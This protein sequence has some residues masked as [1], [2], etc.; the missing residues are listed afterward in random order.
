[1][2]KKAMIWGISLAFVVTGVRAQSLD[3]A[4]KAIDAEQ[5]AQ[6]KGML[7]TLVSN[8]PKDGVNYFY[9]GLVYIHNEHLDSALNV[10]NQ[11]LTADPKGNLNKVGQG[12]VD[13]YKE[14]GSAAATK[15][16][17]ATA[18]LKRKDYLE[19][20]HI[21]RAYIDA[22]QPD[23]QKAVEYLDQAKA[24]NSEDPL[25]P[26]ALG[27]AYFGLENPSQAYV[28]YRNA[29]V[30]DNTLTRAR[31]QM[32]V[33]TRGSHAWQEAIDGLKQ[34]ATEVP[35]YAPT[36]RELAETY[37]A[38]ANTATAIDDY[39]A[40]NKEAVEFYKQYMDKTDYTVESRIRYA[41]FLVYVKDYTELQAQAAELAQLEDVN[42]KV[43][44][45]LGYS[46]YENKQYQESKE[47]L[48]K[49][50]TRMEAERIIPLDYLH[51]GLTDV[52][53]ATA[54]DAV[55]EAVFNDGI[56]QLKKAV[57]LDSSIADDLHEVGMDLVTNK[58]KYALAAKVF[59][60]PA[61]T[62]TSRNYVFDNFYVGFA[63]YYGVATKQL[64]EEPAR[65]E[66]LQKADTALGLVIEKA[67]TTQDAYL[68]RANVNNL[69]DDPENPKGLAE[70]YFLKYIEMVK[71]KGDSE[72]QKN[73]NRLVDAY[74]TI[75]VVSVKR[76][77]YQK[78]RDLIGEI[79]KLDPENAWAKQTLQYLEQESAAS[80]GGTTGQ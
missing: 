64:A 15:F 66:W 43:L 74:S 60:I 62:P 7:E 33:I 63:T 18:G 16:A 65:T 21:G 13:L 51:L 9:L 55:D 79:L 53:I 2:M 30:L 40:R 57:E 5:F 80:T 41:D 69:L 50:F 4:K 32:Q 26:L 23:Y 36:Y 49:L 48:D 19:L 17:E 35:D 72:V 37:H 6:A 56:A 68:F 22:P 75:A 39:N 61:A 34:I 76:G 25:V 12:I 58:K 29:T 42:P 54:N 44:R 71:E 46:A 67:P 78:G 27:D 73:K 1:M 70:P 59:E 20:Y 10:F 28:N 14:N 38:W 11:G 52:N 47:A 45:Y 3:D 77:E 8:K 31:V 24:K